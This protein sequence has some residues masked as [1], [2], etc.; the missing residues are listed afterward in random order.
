MQRNNIP[1]A[2]YAEFTKDSFNEGKEYIQQHAL[3]N[4]LKAE[5]WDA[6]TGVVLDQTKEEAL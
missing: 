3:P 2:A 1:T 4:V 6:G 5:G